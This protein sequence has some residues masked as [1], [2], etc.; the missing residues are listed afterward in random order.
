MRCTLHAAIWRAARGLRRGPIFVEHARSQWPAALPAVEPGGHNA[1][2]GGG[3]HLRLSPP[4]AEIGDGGG[5][6]LCWHDN[7]NDVCSV[8]SSA[9]ID[10]DVI[11]PT[12][13]S[14]G[15]GSSW[16]SV[17]NVPIHPR[18]LQTAPPGE[19]GAGGVA[20]VLSMEG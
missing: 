3:R 10:P 5:G 15:F 16:T 18:P 19:P 2:V 12:A 13:C 6:L 4:P 7:A 1:V 8:D 14:D 11:V 17:I 9:I 20:L